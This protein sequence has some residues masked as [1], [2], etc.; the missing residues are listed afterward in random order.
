MMTLVNPHY[1]RLMR[2]IAEARKREGL[3]RQIDMVRASGL[4]KSTISRLEQGQELGEASLRA[5]AKTIGWTGDSAEDVLAG[6]EPT[7][8]VAAE[9]QSQAELERRYQRGQA[10][11]AGRPIDVVEDALYKVFMAASPGTPLAEFDRVR[12]QVFGVLAE[13]GIDV[14]ERHDETSSGTDT[15]T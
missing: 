12:R 6:G 15:D 11:D 9:P 5:I 8:A 2:L 14:A 3:E 1:E 4:S 13:A 10:T 7:I